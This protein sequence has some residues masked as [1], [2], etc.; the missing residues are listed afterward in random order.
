MLLVFVPAVR[1]PLEAAPKYRWIPRFEAVSLLLPRNVERAPVQQEKEVVVDA[2]PLTI[3]STRV[4]AN[5]TT[6]RGR[7]LVTMTR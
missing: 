4:I 3:G 1:R 7:W 5:T 2:V 6:A